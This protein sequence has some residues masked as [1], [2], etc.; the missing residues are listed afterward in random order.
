MTRL[1]VTLVL[2][3]VACGGR[4]DPIDASSVE[5]ASDGSIEDSSLSL[6]GEA[7]SNTGF[8]FVDG[9]LACAPDAGDTA[10]IVTCCGGQPCAGRCAQ[11]LDGG[12]IFCECAGLT[13]G[14]PANYMCCPGDNIEGTCTNQC[15]KTGTH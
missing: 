6:D 14:C 8:V 7:D 4:E 13:S 2:L 9:G 5:D 3:T 11:W 15:P 1:T 10:A 12:G